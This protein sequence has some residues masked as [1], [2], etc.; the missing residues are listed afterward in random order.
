MSRAAHFNGATGL[1]N[2]TLGQLPSLTSSNLSCGI[3]SYW[4]RS[5]VS[6]LS[7]IA[8]AYSTTAGHCFRCYTQ[9]SG[10]TAAILYFQPQAPQ[11]TTK[12]GVTFVGF[13]EL[14]YDDKWHHVMMNWNVD[15]SAP[16]ENQRRRSVASASS[17]GTMPTV[18]LV[19][20]VSFGP[21]RATVATG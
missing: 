18:S 5:A 16:S 8:C 10:A 14:P 11:G 21:Q 2:A 4:Y 20:L 3:F 6:A 9:P 15:L 13:T 17:A 19:A 7:T 12:Q 1:F